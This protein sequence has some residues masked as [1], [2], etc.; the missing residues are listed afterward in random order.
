MYRN[1]KTFLIPLILSAFIMNACNDN[2][3]SPNPTDNS[4]KKTVNW[5][6]AADSSSNA[7]VLNYWNAQDDY[8]NTDNQGNRQFQY[9]PQAHALDVL[10]RAYLR[11]NDQMYRQYI[12]QWYDGVKTQ[13]GGNFLNNF[14]DDMEWNALAMLRAYKATNE[15]RFKTAAYNVWDE[16]K[17]G[18]TDVADGGIM[19][20]KNTPNNKNAPANGPACILAA[21]L[22]MMD[23]NQDNLDWANKIYDWEKNKLVNQS[24]GE[25]WDGIKVQDGQENVNKDW[26]FTYNQGTFIGAA[27]KLYEITGN[28]MYLNDAEK[29][30]DYTLNNLINN[31]DRILK[32][33]GPGDGG[34]FKGIFIRYFVQL[35]LNKD[36]EDA[37][38]Q[39]YVTFL[40]HN[41]KILWLEGTNKSYV[42]FGT[43]W[44]EK[45]GNTV[46]LKTNLSGA[47]LMEQTARVANEG[48]IEDN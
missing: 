8:F 5:N 26:I 46:D 35:I 15:D 21:N 31:T 19:W 16:I 7:L 22:Y 24:K 30:A 45:P 32:D 1:I 17:T 40:K 29:A 23:H 2:G 33:E 10:V 43:Y 3:I 47:I 38:R 28:R 39:R 13:T 48:L 12:D 6:S 14:Y 11:T 36:L 44:K 20:S 41:A 27:L 18:W 42:I 9:W 25:V 4:S 37:T 34:L